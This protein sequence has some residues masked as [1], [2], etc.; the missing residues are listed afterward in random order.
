L[1]RDISVDLC[2]IVCA[3]IAEGLSYHQAAARSKVS[4]SSAIRSQARLRD[5]GSV[6]PQPQDGDR[7]RQD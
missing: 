3:A 7:V 5:A 2:Q 1:A 6:A 4:V